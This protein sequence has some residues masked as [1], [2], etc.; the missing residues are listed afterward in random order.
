MI[1]NL[2]SLQVSS[3]TP[4]PF[5]PVEHMYHLLANQIH[6]EQCNITFSYKS[7]LYYFP[8]LL[9]QEINCSMDYSRPIL[10][11]I[12]FFKDGLPIW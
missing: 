8:S 7:F 1:P 3:L 10:P 12:T 6:L 5:I 2:I 4:T 11:N 9:E